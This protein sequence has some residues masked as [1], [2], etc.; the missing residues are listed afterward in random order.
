VADKSTT[1]GVVEDCSAVPPPRSMED[2]IKALRA[3]R[4]AKGLCDRCA[5]K[6]FK[7]HTCAASVQLHAM[8]QVF[9]LLPIEETEGELHS[10]EAV[11]EQLF[12]AIS[13]Q[14]VSGGTAKRSLQMMGVMQQQMINI[15]IDSGNTHSFISQNLVDKLSNLTL[16]P[17]AVSVTVADGS[18]MQCVSMVSQAVWT[19]QH[20][21]F[22]Q[23]LKV[24]PLP[25]FD[26]ILG[27]DW[28]GNTSG[29]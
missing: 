9:E 3:Y 13:S 2:K 27:M 10:D 17:A 18:A 12:L 14:A 15:L 11:E 8:Q 25:T 7:G 22:S 26:L 21:E 6:W 4:R 19:I 20:R 23:D 16:L 24:L 29:Y 1:M 5:E 28:L